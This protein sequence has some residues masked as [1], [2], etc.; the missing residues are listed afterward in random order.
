MTRIEQ[1]RLVH[2]GSSATTAPA[3]DFVASELSSEGDEWEPVRIG[4]PTAERGEDFGTG[5]AWQGT[6]ALEELEAPAALPGCSQ[7]EAEAP[8][9]LQRRVAS[10]AEQLCAVPS[11][12]Q[13]ASDCLRTQSAGFL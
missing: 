6:A 13:V 12:M 8:V 5:A 11:S 1:K 10:A 7:C 3:D 9:P 2:N 4:R